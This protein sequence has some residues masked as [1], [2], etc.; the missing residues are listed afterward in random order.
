[1]T[2][3]TTAPADLAA[4][5]ALARA[6]HA[7]ATRLA[8]RVW[9]KVAALRDVRLWLRRDAAVA[10]LAHAIYFN[11]GY[12]AC[13]RYESAGEF[14]EDFAADLDEAWPERATRDGAEHYVLRPFFAESAEYL[15]LLNFGS[16]RACALS[17][18][19]ALDVPARARPAG[20]PVAGLDEE[21]LKALIALHRSAALG[22]VN[23]LR[24][25]DSG[26]YYPRWAMGRLSEKR[27]DLAFVLEDG[28]PGL[29]EALEALVALPGVEAPMKGF[30]SEWDKKCK[31]PRLD[32]DSTLAAFLRDC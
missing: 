20:S 16:M 7:G 23:A 30:S 15:H 1:M 17:D 24:Y 8:A 32:L 9:E 25:L 14:A 21:E 28:V 26:L 5:L 4:E 3:P 10:Y 27:S 22:I 2:T 13:E 6:I 29:L 11:A 12:D 19:A 18:L 31:V